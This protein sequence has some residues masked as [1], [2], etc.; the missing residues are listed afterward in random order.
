[1]K[2]FCTVNLDQPN[3]KIRRLHGSNLGPK[4]TRHSPVLHQM[5]AGLEI[6]IT[7]LHDGPLS[8][9][10]TKMVDIQHIFPNW[11]TDVNDPRNYYFD[12]TDQYLQTIRECGSDIMYR[13]GTS[14]EFCKPRRFSVPPADYEKWSE[15]CLN[16]V[17][18]Y[19]AGWKNGF[20]WDIKYWEVWNEP[21][22]GGN[23][24][25]SYMWNGD[26]QQFIDLYDI[27]VRKIKKEF[28]D[29]KVGGASFW[30]YYNNAPDPA[31]HTFRREFLEACAER[32]L[33]LDFLSWH[34]YSS[35]ALPFDLIDEPIAARKELDELGFTETELHNTE[36]H[37]IHSWNAFYNVNG[38]H[39]T[40][41]ITS[42]AHY[43]SVLTAWQDTPMDM[44][45]FYTIG[46]EGMFAPIYI[47]RLMPLYYGMKAFTEITH[48]PD[49]VTA[50]SDT[51]N[52]RILAGKG[53]NNT[54]GVLISSFKTAP[55]T[56]ELDL[57]G[58]AVSDITVYR[59]DRY[60][61]NPDDSAW[62][63]WNYELTAVEAEFKDGKA[64]LPLFA[65][66]SCIYLIKGKYA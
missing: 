10:G 43:T 46:G 30:K 38:E 58:A 42:A 28:P 9:P 24:E 36:W 17:R 49:R 8:N 39:G 25:G 34:R 13:L 23:S 59:V 18:H 61:Y 48:F 41:S 37:Y 5:Y 11:E 44:G 14:I 16:I 27:T 22:D 53:E 64:Q 19:N 63:P 15:I 54:F 2:A 35:E 57:K 21:D 40:G 60:F 12:Q 56:L 51:E 6:P 50:V 45:Y 4:I 26:V 65:N 66:D 52:L 7:R 33:P 3:G 31:R 62:G 47:A 1:M 29:V 32:K 55:E 20:F